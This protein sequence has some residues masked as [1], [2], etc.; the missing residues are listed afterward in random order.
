MN[1]RIFLQNTGAC[2][3]DIF[4]GMYGEELGITRTYFKCL[5]KEYYKQFNIDW[6]VDDGISP[7]CVNSICEKYDISHY[8]NSIC[9]KY[10]ISHYVFDISKNCFVENISKIEI[11]KHQFILLL[12][13]IYI[14]F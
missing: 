2:V 11:I 6:T 9:E 4:I 8:V 13:I 3:I 5:A 1:T 14:L 10:D 7:R 12:I